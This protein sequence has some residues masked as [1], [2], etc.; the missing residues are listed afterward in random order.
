[1]RGL[2]EVNMFVF[3]VI[4][5]VA[6]SDLVYGCIVSPFFVENYVR[7][8]W[9]RSIDYCRLGKKLSKKS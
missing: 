5:T 8:N 7:Y 6:I 2:L 3:P 1:M 4:F 9:A